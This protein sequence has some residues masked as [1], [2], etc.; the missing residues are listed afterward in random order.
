MAITKSILQNVRQQTVVKLL[1]DATVGTANV[2][3]VDIKLADETFLG[4]AL[5]NVNIQ[6][7]IFSASDSSVNP[8]VIA[9]GPTISSALSTG[10]VMFLHGADSFE[11]DQGAGFHDQTLNNSNIAVQMPPQSMLY[12]VLGKSAGYQEPDQQTK[13]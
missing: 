9:R 12:L 7:V 13:K 1:N 4:E 11:L 8:I 6:T 3:L 5:C 2:N 10:N